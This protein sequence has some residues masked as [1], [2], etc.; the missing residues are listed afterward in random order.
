MLILDEVS[1]CIHDGLVGQEG[2]AFITG[3]SHITKVNWSLERPGDTI[4]V[5]TKTRSSYFV[6]SV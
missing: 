5:K 6:S 2:L 4:L 1:I 3:K